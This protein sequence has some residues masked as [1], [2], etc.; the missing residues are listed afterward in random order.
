MHYVTTDLLRPGAPIVVL[1][2]L[3]ALTLLAML[4]W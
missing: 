1:L 3:C 2:A 4:V